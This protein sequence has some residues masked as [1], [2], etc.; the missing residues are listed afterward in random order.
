MRIKKTE[1]EARVDVF[2]RAAEKVANEAVP[3]WKAGRRDDWDRV[4]CA[5]MNRLT[6]GAGLRISLK[7]EER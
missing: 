2:I 3:D 1:H 4:F 6:M 5:E 7:N